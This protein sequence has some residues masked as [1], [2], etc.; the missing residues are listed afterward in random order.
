MRAL[1]RPGGAHGDDMRSRSA[2]GGQHDDA[3]P[4]RH[5]VHVIYRLAV[6]G[7]ENGLVNLVN[8]LPADAWRHTIVSLTDVDDAFAQRVVARNVEIVALGKGPGHAHRAYPRLWRLF[9]GCRPAIVHT[10]N[11]AGLEIAPVAWAA[12]VPARL[13]GEHGRDADDPDGSNVRRRRI[14][15]FY[16]RFVTRY[17]ALSPDL[18]TYLQDAVGVPADRIEQIYNG[19]D[20]QRFTPRE[21]REPIEGC[22]FVDPGLAII[23]A[24]G[25]LDTVKDHANLAS[26]FVRVLREHPALR[27]TLRL[28]IVGEG[29]ERS[30]VEAILEGGGVR[31]LA[32]L[33]GARHDVP[34]VLR[35]L[36]LFVLP[37]FGEGVSNTILEAMAAGLP[38]VATRVGANADLV[39]DGDTGCIVPPSDDA[40]LASAIAGYATD[41]QRAIAHGRAGRLRVEQRFSLQRMIDRYHRLYLALINGAGD[42]ARDAGGA[43]RHHASR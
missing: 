6:G 37:S 10:R 17:V 21:A 15:R 1:G 24:V 40:A 36:D 34:A 2:S 7:L 18:A 28:V 16:R 27:A 5:I 14:R 20:V 12:G 42:T 13:H 38:V 25:R 9:R 23:G 31:G 35:G 29:P 4:P 33:P 8:G 11:L 32:W 19:V 30:R 41:P 22:P 3:H 39:A 26:A 43:T